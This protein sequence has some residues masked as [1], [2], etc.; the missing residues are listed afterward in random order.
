MVEQVSEYRLQLW[1]WKLRRGKCKDD[2]SK[3]KRK[4]RRKIVF[5]I[6]GESTAHNFKNNRFISLGLHLR[7][8]LFSFE[9]TLE[10]IFMRSSRV[11]MRSFELPMNNGV[12]NKSNVLLVVFLSLSSIT[13]K[14]FWPTRY[15][16]NMEEIIRWIENVKKY[17]HLRSEYEMNERKLFFRSV[18]HCK[19]LQS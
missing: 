15:L 4:R 14:V 6:A 3:R 13:K 19:L 10:F 7:S 1:K 18:V 11:C 8:V 2:R 9:P 16:K 12:I 17:S 5:L